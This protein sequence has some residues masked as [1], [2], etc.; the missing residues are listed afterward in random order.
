MAV[1]HQSFSDV[2][3]IISKLSGK[4][5]FS[6]AMDCFKTVD[7]YLDIYDFS[8]VHWVLDAKKVEISYSDLVQIIEATNDGML[9]TGGDMRVI[10]LMVIDERAYHY[11]TEELKNRYHWATYPNFDTAD[12]AVSFSK[13]INLL[14]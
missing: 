4:L 3:L 11:L 13:Y 1:E 6:D 7:S 9:G 10:P 14:H 12:Q 2:P 5:S 8:M